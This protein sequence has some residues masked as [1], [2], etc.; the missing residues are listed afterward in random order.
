MVAGILVDRRARVPREVH[1]KSVKISRA[2]GDELWA[3]FF[4]PASFKNGLKRLKIECFFYGSFVQKNRL[5][6][7]CEDCA[8]GRRIEGRPRP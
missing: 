1:G 4:H 7:T 5:L 2:L 6:S 3:V 8:W